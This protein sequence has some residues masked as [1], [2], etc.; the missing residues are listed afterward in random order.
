VCGDN[1]INLNAIDQPVTEKY[2]ILGF[3]GRAIRSI[4]C[5]CWFVGGLA[6]A[7]TIFPQ[8]PPNPLWDGNNFGDMIWIGPGWCGSAPDPKNF[9]GQDRKKIAIDIVDWIDKN[10]Q[11]VAK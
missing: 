1:V 11:A 2:W 7:Q 9:L 5:V 3:A 8:S 10:C 4:V 6:S